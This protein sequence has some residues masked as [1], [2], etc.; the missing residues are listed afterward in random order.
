MEH[1]N[2]VV[3]AAYL[4]EQLADAKHPIHSA[5]KNL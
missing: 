4:K 3:L 1:N 5:K 2:A